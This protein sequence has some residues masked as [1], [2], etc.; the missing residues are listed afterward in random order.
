MIDVNKQNATSH[1]SAMNAATAQ[2]VTLTSGGQQQTDYNA[3]G[4]AVFSISTNLGD[5]S[6]DIMMLA[7]LQQPSDDDNQQSNNADNRLLSAAKRLCSTFTEF[8]KLVEP[9]SNEPRQNLFSAVSRIGEAGNE[10]MHSL[11]SNEEDQLN[12]SNGGEPRLQE[13]IIGMAKMVASSTVS[14]IFL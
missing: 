3:V 6:K 14:L 4:A 5:F 13:I 1:L 11:N 9:E 2:V 10:V 7:A 12:D 8:L